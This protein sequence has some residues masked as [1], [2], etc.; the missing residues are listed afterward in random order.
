MLILSPTYE[1]NTFLANPMHVV[2][3]S[4]HTQSV[5]SVS[6]KRAPFFNRVTGE[7][8]LQVDD[9]D[10]QQFSIKVCM[11]HHREE[12]YT[13]TYSEMPLEACHIGFSQH[14]M[15]LY[16]MNNLC[17]SSISDHIGSMDHHTEMIQKRAE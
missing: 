1:N 13:C 7:G 4:P 5:C 8:L 9:T 14:S 12:A 10:V 11:H 17:G 6:Y 3:N 16:L 2:T 15:L